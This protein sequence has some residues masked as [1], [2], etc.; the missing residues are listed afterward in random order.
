MFPPLSPVMVSQLEQIGN[1]SIITVKTAMEYRELYAEH[2]LMFGQEFNLEEYSAT[3]KAAIHL[4]HL[5]HMGE[6]ENI[7]SFCDEFKPDE[8]RIIV[9]E[10][11]YHMYYGNVLHSTMYV[12]SD[13]TGIDLYK[14]FR[15]AGAVPCKNYYGE[16]PCENRA[17]RWTGIPNMHF[18]RNYLEFISTYD[19]VK[20][21]EF[22]INNTPVPTPCFCDYHHQNESET[23]DDTSG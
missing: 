22:S 23:E 2:F 6:I 16:L 15:D 19:K 4:D 9:N 13:K 7:H 10:K 5:L 20:E 18:N 21:Y 11:P 17:C 8:L 1:P 12:Y 3:E 14:F